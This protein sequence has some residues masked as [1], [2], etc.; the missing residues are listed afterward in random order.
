MK[1]NKVLLVLTLGL[2]ASL[3]LAA[4]GTG[5]APA[6]PADTS[7]PQSA[8]PESSSVTEE[9]AAAETQSPVDVPTESAPAA[10]VS[11]S[12]DIMPIFENSCINCHG[13]R[14]VDEGL[15]LNT[16]AE[17]MLGSDNG[18]VIVAGNPAKSLLVKL[19][20]DKKMPKRGA[21]LNAE[22]IQLITDWVASGAPNN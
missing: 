14:R 8:D 4:C 22:Q 11:Y 20:T 19:V 6:Q 16:Y 12:A 17:L 21:K 10:T 15:S 2:T 13:G 9:P 18:A 5:A 1:R 7:A 3:M